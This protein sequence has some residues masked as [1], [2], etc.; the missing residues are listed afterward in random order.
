MFDLS[1]VYQMLESAIGA[2]FATAG[3]GYARKKGQNVTGRILAAFAW[4]V[5]WFLIAGL[6]RAFI[7]PEGFPS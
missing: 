2:V 4:L 5:V 7:L 1:T 3:W 6:I